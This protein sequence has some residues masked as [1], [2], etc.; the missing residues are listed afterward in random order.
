MLWMEKRFEN[1][2]QKRQAP[3]HADRQRLNG[4]ILVVF[5][6]DE[7]GEEIGF[8]VDESERLSPRIDPLA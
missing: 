3:V 1:V 8:A 5:V 7:A 4:D 2:A 6:D